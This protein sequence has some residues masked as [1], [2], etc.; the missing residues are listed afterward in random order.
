MAMVPGYVILLRCQQI[1]NLRKLKCSVM[2]QIDKGI[3]MIRRFGLMIDFSNNRYSATVQKAVQNGKIEWY[4][5]KNPVDTDQKQLLSL[6][7]SHGEYELSVQ[8]T[9]QYIYNFYN[10]DFQLGFV[11]KESNT[12][13]YIFYTPSQIAFAKTIKTKDSNGDLCF[14]IV[15][16]T[17]HKR[18]AI[19][20]KVTTQSFFTRLFNIFQDANNGNSYWHLSVLQT[21]VLDPRIVSAFVSSLVMDN[22][23]E[24][25]D[26]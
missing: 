13:N 16:N 15:Q 18:L 1:W 19:L 25:S 21:D 9:S 22:S 14:E 26:L 6:Y 23:S 12:Q 10:K 11:K 2:V 8:K 24:F 17:N 20:T 4:I 5:T 3:G 7:D